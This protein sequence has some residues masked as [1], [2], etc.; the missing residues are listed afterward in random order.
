[1]A[2]DY[3]SLDEVIE[4][5]GK[6]K[7]EIKKLISEGKLHE[8]RDGPKPVYKVS[9]VDALPSE[10]S[11]VDMAAEASSVELVPD[12]TEETPSEDQGLR[13]GINLGEL[14]SADT[15]VSTTGINV[16]GDTDDDYKLAD[17]TESE[18]QI[19]ESPESSEQLSG[20]DGELD[21]DGTVGSGSGLLDLS[22]QAD[23]TSLGAVL[24]DI[25][26]S[27]GKAEVAAPGAEDVGLAEEAD[28]I[29]EQAE[30]E[31]VMP[32]AVEPPAAPRY[33]E[34][35]ADA[36]SN[37]CGIVLLVALL[38]MI[39]AAIVL[40]AGFKNIVPTILKGVEGIIWYIATGLALVVICVV[41]FAALLGGREGKRKKADIYKQPT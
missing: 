33:V 31:P 28:K 9:E 5:L 39:Y 12:E 4:K 30:P 19:V 37:A 36:V 38:V 26:P 16:L 17:D 6:S 21:L 11:K 22:L 10:V 25:L 18:T 32:V 27:A 8:Y 29:F 20:L 41:G 34:P 24:D 35:Q 7:D 15:T 40:T 13:S 2:E 23:D 14:T 1:M 3:Y